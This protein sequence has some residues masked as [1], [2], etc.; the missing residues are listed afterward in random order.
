M[1]R[2]IGAAGKTGAVYPWKP[3]KGWRLPERPGR[4]PRRWSRIG[5]SN[6]APT[7]GSACCQNGKGSE[8]GSARLRRSAEFGRD[9]FPRPCRQD[10]RTESGRAELALALTGWSRIL[11]APRLR[12]KDFRS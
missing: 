12:P 8:A 5:G 4:D 11:I 6:L 2:L 10:W 9:S 3:D 1:T 7:S